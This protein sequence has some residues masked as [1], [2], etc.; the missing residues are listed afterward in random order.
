MKWSAQRTGDQE[1]H[2]SIPAIT[3]KFFSIWMIEKMKQKRYDWR[4]W[5][6]NEMIEEN[7]TKTGRLK[8]WKTITDDCKKFNNNG[9]LEKCNNNGTFEKWNDNGTLKKWN[10]NKRFEKWNNNGKN[11]FLETTGHELDF[12]WRH[13]V[14]WKIIIIVL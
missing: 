3:R 2:G 14:Y 11:G 6:K 7:E 12:K 13:R 5:N 10:H 1:V 4:K 9:T 8:K